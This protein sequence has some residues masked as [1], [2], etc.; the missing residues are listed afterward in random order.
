MLYQGKTN[1][2]SYFP[3]ILG[4]GDISLAPDCEG[5]L[6]YSF[7]Q[8]EKK[9][10]SAFDGIVVRCGRRS[11]NNCRVGQS[12]LFSFGKFVFS[13][14]SQI[15]DWSQELVEDKG[16]VQ[17]T[18]AYKD[19][20]KIFTKSFIHPERN[21]YA[22]N[23]TFENVGKNKK[24]YYDFVLE[25]YSEAIDELTN[26]LYAKKERDEACIGFRIYGMDIYSG[27]IR[28]CTN[29]EYKTEPIPNGM[30]FEFE[31]S[32]GESVALFY[33]LEDNLDS[34]D[35]IE[36]LNTIKKKIDG[37]GYEGLLTECEENYKNFFAL[38]YVET[39]DKKLNEIYKTSLYDLKCY[40]T[41]HS[42]PIGLNNGYWHGRYFAFD[43]YYSF[44]ALLGANRLELAKRVPTFRADV[45]LE[46]AIQY[47]SD[48]HKREETQEMAK[49]LW[50]TGEKADIELSPIGTWLDHV[51]HMP[52]IGLGAFEFYEYTRD[53]DFL[54]KCYRM[55]RACAKYFTN[56]MVYRDGERFYI[57]K[58]TD[59]E[60]LGAAVENPFMT[61]CGAIKL[62]ECCAE[63]SEILEIDKD[64]RNECR[65]IASELRKSLPV[66]ND[67]YVPHTGCTQK[68]IAVFAGKF[69]F[70][71]IDDYDKKLLNAWEDFEKHGEKYGN[72]YPMGRKISPWYA[73]WK[74]ISYAR[75]NM[76]EKAYHALTESYESAGVFHEMFEI[77][78]PAVR[79]KPWFTTACGMFISSV[80][81][82]LL[83]SDGKTVNILPAF[84]LE[85]G[86]ISFKL[87]IKGGAVAEVKIKD[88]KLVHLCITSN[89]EDVTK[90]FDIL[91]KGKKYR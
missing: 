5:T 36:A 85:K 7:E 73:C 68:S 53:K 11:N 44:Y 66:E 89:G 86:D 16:Y 18:C 59:L 90:N 58:C 60:R 77:N 41:K 52:V 48:C 33:Y 79:I 15:E 76:P 1:A 40:T 63:A 80:N 54:K 55:I 24:F 12:K 10:L 62:L 65:F 42:I 83:Q 27:E 71:V 82:M 91:F 13:E 6:N 87:A 3:P 34:D 70:H 26:I 39:P 47:G 84:P 88:R 64:Y 23:K 19:G 50:E 8:Y 49:F 35:Y 38:G 22:I 72:M 61:S 9:G 75:A 14:G 2:E 32:D 57:G 4:N 51:F 69:P 21:I 45:C 46:T 17:S 74:A 37:R 56:Y 78:E 67:M 29:K 30:R 20:A 81:E 43:E 25:G 31:A 28:L